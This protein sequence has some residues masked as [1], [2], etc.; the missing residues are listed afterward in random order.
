P[1]LINTYTLLAFGG[2][3]RRRYSTVI[4][5]IRF[6]LTA[7]LT[8]LETFHGMPRRNGNERYFPH[9]KP[10]RRPFGF[11]YHRRARTVQ[12]G[13]EQHARRRPC[14]LLRALQI[15]RLQ[16]LSAERGRGDA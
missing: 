15:K 10:H 9:Q 4:R 11:K 1:Y 8:V 6:G 12:R 13:L 2:S 3:Q 7:T 5:G 14:A 16:S